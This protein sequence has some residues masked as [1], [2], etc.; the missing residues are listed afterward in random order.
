MCEQCVVRVFNISSLSWQTLNL[1]D[2]QMRVLNHG[3]A[4]RPVA[5]AARTS[6]SS[7]ACDCD[8]G[9]WRGRAAVQSV[10][11]Q[12]I[13]IMKPRAGVQPEAIHS[14]S[15]FGLVLSTP[16]NVGASFMCLKTCKAVHAVVY[17]VVS[18][19]A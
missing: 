8:L 18:G 11:R 19:M 6:L 3:C 5:V 7:T 14:R 9:F 1:S 10:S 4:C 16:T 13:Q 15:C 2:V 12:Y 17:G